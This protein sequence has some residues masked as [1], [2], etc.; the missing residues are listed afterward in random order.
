MKSEKDSKYQA[1]D[2]NSLGE[3]ATPYTHRDAIVYTTSFET[4]SEAGFPIYS[5]FL[6][7]F[8]P[9]CDHHLTS[10]FLKYLMSKNIA[11]HT[12]NMGI[13]MPNIKNI[14]IAD[15]R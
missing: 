11:I 5:R 2:M 12:M 14:P 1:Y 9:Q 10:H 8:Q 3:Y 15:L 13:I 4:G 6:F 7:D